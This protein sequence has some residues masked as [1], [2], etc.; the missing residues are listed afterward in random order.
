M[1]LLTLSKN[2]GDVMNDNHDT[3]NPIGIPDEAVSRALNDCDLHL[4]EIPELDLYIDQIL[5][6]VASK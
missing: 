2:G 5:T 6:L 4:S 3:K 1:T